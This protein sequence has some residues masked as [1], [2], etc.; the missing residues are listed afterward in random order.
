MEDCLNAHPELLEEVERLE[1]TW[2]AL[3]F[4][5]NVEPPNPEVDMR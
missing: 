1:A 4:L 5:N 2:Q 3:D